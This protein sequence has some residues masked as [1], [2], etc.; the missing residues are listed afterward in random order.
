MG[1]IQKTENKK[2][3]FFH[4]QLRKVNAMANYPLKQEN[5]MFL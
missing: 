1:Q 4:S 2:T 5:D 3:C